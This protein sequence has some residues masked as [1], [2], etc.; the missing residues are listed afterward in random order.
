[1][2]LLYTIACWL[3]SLCLLQT[4][5][6]QSGY[7]VVAHF[8]VSGNGGWDYI[9]LQPGTNQLY[10][11]H[12]TRV[13]IIDKLSGDSLGI[14]PKTIGVHGLALVPA[15]GKGFTSNVGS[16]TVTVFR[17]DNHAVIDQ[18][19]AG[20]NPDAIFYETYS[21]KIIT[22]NGRSKDLSIIDPVAHKVVHTIAV[23]GKPETAVSNGK[24]KVYEKIEDKNEIAVVDMNKMEVVAHWSIAPGQSPT[25]LVIDNN[26]HRLFAGCDE[27][28]MVIDADN[29]SVVADLPI[30]AG[31]DGLVIDPALHYI[32]TS[33]GVDNMTVVKEMNKDQFE[34]VEKVPTLRGA[35]TSC[36]DERTHTIYLPTAAFEPLQPG[37]KGRPKIKP[38]TFQVL[39]LVHE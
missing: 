2:K 32:C 39:K 8:P 22:C 21:K 35:R 34:V 13:N 29:G 31:C 33:H 1:M 16:N 36:V 18:I 24:G 20:E 17:L 4:A 26:T 25:G 14:I 37:E 19:A 3:L 7:K 10:I 30:G 6:A 5:V 9:N 15:L 27:H 11:A 38:G 28:L 12:G 23:G